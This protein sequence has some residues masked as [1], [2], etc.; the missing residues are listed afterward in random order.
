MAGQLTPLGTGICA[1]AS[2]AVGWS[3]MLGVP[4]ATAFGGH[5]VTIAPNVTYVFVEIGAAAVWGAGPS[6]SASR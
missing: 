6:C 2:L 4:M 5:S 1:A 3:L